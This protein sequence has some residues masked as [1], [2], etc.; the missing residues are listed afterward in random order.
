MN[1]SKI[2]VLCVLNPGA[3][4][5]LALRRWPRIAA[6]LQGCG[7]TWQLL[8]ERDPPVGRQVADRL[9]ADDAGQFAAVVGIGGDGTHSAILNAMMQLQNSGVR[10]SL[11]PYALLPL[12]TGNDIA[13]SFNIRMRDAFFTGDIRRA[14]AAIRYGADYALDLGRIGDV[15]FVDALTIGLDS[16]V[17]REHNR[18]KRELEKIPFLRRLVRGN[19][20]YTWCAGV[21]LLRHHP[22][23][24]E[25]RVD[26]RLW[27]AGPLLNLVVNNTRVYGGEF[28]L[29]PDA[30]ANDG[31]LELVLFTGHTDY[32]A[33]Y[34]LSFRTHPRQIQQMA[35][36]LSH[37]AS[38][39]Q[40]RRFQIKLSR[41][42]LAQYD[43][44]E[45]PSAACFDVEVVPRA[46]CLRLPAEPA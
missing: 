9:A 26:G 42:E 37:C 27:Y 25:I 36:R 29:C 35:D 11:P 13:K 39:V 7:I 43:G 14:V 31:L 8:A 21:R 17:L 30:Y 10:P 41:E 12:G 2:H 40:G 16:T 24:A 45:L 34:L 5:G 18:H 32:L 4:G 15:Y 23:R 1:R 19:L 20:L 22:L 28:V 3:G 33:K 46:I 44:E 6:A 38:T